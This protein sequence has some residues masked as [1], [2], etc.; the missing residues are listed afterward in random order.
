MVVPSGVDHQI[1]YKFCNILSGRL[2][3]ELPLKSAKF[4]KVVN[5]VGPW[6]GYLDIEDKRVRRAN[7]IAATAPWLTTM[8]I[9]VDGGLLYGGIV[10]G[11]Q[12]QM[13]TG[14]VNLSGPDHVG[15][16][17]QRLQHGDYTAYT[18]PEGGVWSPGAGV[19]APKI[20]Y[21]ILKI[22]LEVPYSIPIRVAAAAE[23]PSARYT[24][25]YSAP[26]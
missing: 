7:W 5:G 21:W 9:D 8:W 3:A 22:A 20:A 26:I 10:T 6:S 13:S 2:I 1:T 18:D 16:L 12:Y 14:Q 11:R 19:G 15:Y 4:S 25:P 24:V 17:S 23:Q